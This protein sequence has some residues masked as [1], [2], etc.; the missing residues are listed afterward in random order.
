[1]EWINAE[2]S[3]NRDGFVGLRRCEPPEKLALELDEH[4]KCTKTHT[5]RWVFARA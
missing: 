4:E 5:A 1:M 2:F 3:K